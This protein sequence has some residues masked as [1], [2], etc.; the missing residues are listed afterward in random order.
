M[1]NQY[2]EGLSDPSGRVLS[3]LSRQHFFKYYAAGNK[4]WLQKYNNRYFF[5]NSK[6]F[7]MKFYSRNKNQLWA[8]PTIDSD[9]KLYVKD[10][11]KYFAS[12]ATATPSPTPK[13]TNTPSPT[14]APTPTPTP[15][16]S[17]LEQS[18]LLQ[19]MRVFIPEIMI[20]NYNNAISPVFRALLGDEALVKQAETISKVYYLGIDNGTIVYANKDKSIFFFFGTDDKY[21]VADSVNCYTSL[22]EDNELN[23]LP[24]I[25]FAYAIAQLDSTCPFES[26]GGWIN[27]AN[28]GDIT[29]WPHFDAICKA[30]INEFFSITISRKSTK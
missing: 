23:N 25:A 4:L 5:L 10:P 15:E 30:E 13:P 6:H 29:E 21:K 11:S 2:A 1:E 19:W 14:P 18:E 20:E 27:E 8:F 24:Q 7:T 17:A 28:D 12:K 26:Y 3:V 9:L 16:S 22:K